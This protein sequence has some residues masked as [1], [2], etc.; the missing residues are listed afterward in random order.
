MRQV[1]KDGFDINAHYDGDPSKPVI[2]HPV[3]EPVTLAALKAGNIQETGFTVP[4]Q[5]R[6]DINQV[7]WEIK[8]TKDNNVLG[9]YPIPAGVKM[10]IRDRWVRV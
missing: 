3:M 2:W 8:S 7:M 4:S 1:I 10:C 5:Y 6:N 9:K